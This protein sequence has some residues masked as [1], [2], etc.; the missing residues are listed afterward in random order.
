MVIIPSALPFWRGTL[1]KCPNTAAVL[2]RLSTRLSPRRLRSRVSR[3]EASTRKQ[4]SPVG[5]DR[6][7][8]RTPVGTELD[9]GH[10]RSFDH[11]RAEAAAIVE[12]QFVELGA[13]DVIAVI[14]AQMPITVKTECR[15][16]TVFVR[17]NLRP[18]LVHADPVDLVGNTVQKMAD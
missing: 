13:S 12:Q 3:P 4:A 2:L 17:D 10:P 11:G 18:R 16:L 15:R 6:C 1:R 7:H 8:L 14:D 9:F 5:A